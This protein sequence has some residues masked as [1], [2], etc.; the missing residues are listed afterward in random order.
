MKQP[1]IEMSEFARTIM[2]HKYSHTLTGSMAQAAG[3]DEGEKEEWPNIAYRV[4]K[5]VMKAVGYTMRD[6]LS[7][8]I[9]RMITKRKF[10][11]G[12]RYLYA[13]GRS[14]HQTQNCLLLRC[15]DSREGWS[16]LL[17]NSSMALM[18]GAGIGVDYS[19]LR[20]E[21]A[22]IRRTGGVAT[23]PIPLM[24]IL[25]E[26]GRGIMQGGNRRSA[27]WAGLRWN[28]PDVHKF[29]RIKNWSDGVQQMK[30]QD[31]NFPATLDCT[32]ISVNLDDEFFEAYQDDDHPK[33]SLAHSVYWAVVEQMLSTGEPGFSVNTGKNVTETLRNAPIAGGTWILT[34]HG[35]VQ[36]KDMVGLPTTLWTGHQWAFATFTCT[37]QSTPTITVS[38]TGDRQIT[39]D[40][41]HEFFVRQYTGVGDRRVCEII[42]VAAHNLTVGDYLDVGLHE[43]CPIARLNKLSWTNGFVLGDGSV[44]DVTLCTPEK[45]S[46]GHL[47]QGVR[48][49][50]I[51]DRRGYDRYYFIQPQVKDQIVAGKSVQSFLAGWFDADGS[52]DSDQQRIRLSGEYSLLIQARRLLE[53]LGIV[54]TISK[55]I[56]SGFGGTQDTRNLIILA[57]WVSLFA[58]L[59]PCQRLR[60]NNAK[61]YIPYRKSELTV[62]AIY[63]GPVQDVFCCDVGVEEHSFVAEGVRISNCTEITSRD[64]SDICNLGSLNLARIESVEEFEQCVDLG[65]AF[66][67]AGTVYSDI[68]YPEVDRI[69]GKNRRLGLGLMGVHDWLLQRGR[70]YAPDEE[71]GQWLQKYK[72]STAISHKWADKWELSRS[73]KTRAIAPTGTI[74]IIAETTGGLE[75]I[76]CVAY[77]RRYLKG[78]DWCYQYVVDPTAKR[79]IED[80]GV[81]PGAIEEAYILAQDVEKR[82]AFQA[83]VQQYVDHGISSTI[84]LPHW[85]SE[86]NNANTVRSFGSML[87]R[88]LPSLRGITCYPDGGRSGQPLV[89]CSYEE[90][91]KHEGIELVEEPTLVC[92]MARG[93]DCGA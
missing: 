85:G 28:H 12:G 43:G 53:T 57:E 49:K 24:Q 88:Y 10:L 50:T 72:K 58:T 48:S 11:P 16:E 18:T 83:W 47:L 2:Q 5:H 56:K 38:F 6:K 55:P 74:S 59:I 51:D 29:I 45:K 76:F 84:N 35:Y 66:L 52:Y 78:D 33:Y 80:R 61:T 46:L 1:K 71:L 87:M 44:S 30:A 37:K 67:M 63:E 32:N 75:P 73:K 89:P 81:D 8:D 60:L 7:Q 62:T 22:K 13:S 17:H 90:A 77:K 82:V 9:C 93:G 86:C 70:P 31:F 39:C 65:V 69:R 91:V 23:G 3:I 42:R 15:H 68:P 4:T 25:N 27:I 79:L 34:A 19:D 21:G 64:D 14:Y 41:S 26:C 40:P 36:V 20:H 54:A 92:D